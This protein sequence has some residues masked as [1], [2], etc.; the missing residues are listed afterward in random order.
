[1]KLLKIPKGA[2]VIQAL[3]AIFQTVEKDKEPA[4]TDINGIHVLMFPVGNIQKKMVESFQ[5]MPMA[6]G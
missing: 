6:E 1:V 4:M 2:S 3:Y 5:P